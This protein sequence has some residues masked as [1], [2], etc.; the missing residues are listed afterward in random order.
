MV[1]GL[2]FESV[3]F[4]RE[5]VRDQVKKSVKKNTFTPAPAPED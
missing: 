1:F 3:Q 2:I 5:L 4:P